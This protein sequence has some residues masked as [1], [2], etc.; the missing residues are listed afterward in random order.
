ME[1][2]MSQ[3]SDLLQE[4]KETN[5]ILFKGEHSISSRLA[6]LEESLRTCQ[7]FAKERRDNFVKL[8]VVAV[9]AALTAVVAIIKSFLTR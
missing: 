3:L 1:N 8:W 2:T 6:T 9:G 5:M 4:V 7:S